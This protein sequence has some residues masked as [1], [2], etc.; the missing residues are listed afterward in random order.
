[1]DFN[2]DVWGEIKQF[3][4]IY[5]ITTDWKYAENVGLAK[6]KTFYT[7]ATRKRIKN[8]S[9]RTTAQQKRALLMFFYKKRHSFKMMRYFADLVE[10][11]APAPPTI[12]FKEPKK[13]F[14]KYSVG[15]EVI[16]RLRGADERCG[17]IRKVNKASINVDFY[18]IK[19]HSQRPH[20]PA[21]RYAWVKYKFVENKTI[22]ANF[23]TKEEHGNYDDVFTYTNRYYAV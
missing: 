7:K 18:D 1:M 10:E 22:R 2:D 21:T 8:L 6:L 14:T 20:F 13:D 15:Q 23:Q 12:K 16:Y 11:K 19:Y 17:V 3:A 5:H 4:G 9:T